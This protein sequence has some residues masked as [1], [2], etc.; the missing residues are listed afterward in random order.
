MEQAFQMLKSSNRPLPIELL[1][2]KTV[3][4]SNSSKILLEA[5]MSADGVSRE[6]QGQRPR[7]IKHKSGWALT[8]R[9]LPSDVVDAEKQ[10]LDG[11]SKLLRGVEKQITRKVRGCSLET[12]LGLVVVYLQRNGFESMKAV[13]RGRKDEIHLSVQDRRFAGKFRVAVVLRKDSTGDVI[14]PDA[15]VDLR[16]A[17]HH[18]GAAG[19]LIITSGR[20]DE[21]ARR[22]A[23][24]PNLAPIALFDADQLAAE[25]AR[26]GIG[27]QSR[28]LKIP[29]FDE[30]FFKSN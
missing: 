30:S 17:L 22:E 7:F 15:V 8:D 20:V 9:D 27:A 28:A 6:A 10:I 12:L 21:E 24:M 4:A 18:Y 13:P 5:L 3:G 25:L 14:G 16:G 29:T 19:G 11:R 23:D 1:T 2:E 26:H